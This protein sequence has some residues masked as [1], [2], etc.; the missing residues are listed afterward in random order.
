MNIQFLMPF[1]PC[2]LWASKNEF[3]LLRNPGC[4]FEFLL[5]IHLP[6]LSLPITINL[7]QRHLLDNHFAFTSLSF[8]TPV[9]CILS[10]QTHLYIW[11]C[12]VLSPNSSLSLSLPCLI[13]WQI[14]IPSPISYPRGP[15][16]SFFC[17]YWIQI[18]WVPDTLL[19]LTY[20]C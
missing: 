3:L 19:A 1:P 11:E 2:L 14:R 4:I 10:L 8:Q 16:S 6:L 15:H 17:H 12:S 13:P 7:S 9:F 5:A 20:P 18:L